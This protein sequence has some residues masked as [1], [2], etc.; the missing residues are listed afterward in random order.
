MF[1]RFFLLGVIFSFLTCAEG[2]GK[3]PKTLTTTAEGVITQTQSGTDIIETIA[4]IDDVSSSLE[5]ISVT[6]NMQS[7]FITG[8]APLPLFAP[9]SVTSVYKPDVSCPQGST[10]S[11]CTVTIPYASGTYSVG[12]TSYPI[13]A[14]LCYSEN[15]TTYKA[16]LI[17]SDSVTNVPNYI[18][19][20]NL[21]QLVSVDPSYLPVVKEFV[22]HLS[23]QTQI[24]SQSVYFFYVDISAEKRENYPD[25]KIFCGQVTP[26][27]SEWIT[28]LLNLDYF[29]SITGGI[30]L[31][32]KTQYADVDANFVCEKSKINEISLT[33]NN[34]PVDCV[35][36]FAQGVFSSYITSIPGISGEID[37]GPVIVTEEYREDGT[38]KRTICPQKF[39]CMESYGTY[40]TGGFYPSLCSTVAFS[41]MNPSCSEQDL[42]S[43]GKTDY[44]LSLF[45]SSI[46]FYSDGTAYGKLCPPSITDTQILPFQYSQNFS[47]NLTGCF[48]FSGVNCSS[49][50]CPTFDE[51]YNLLKIVST[52]DI[53]TISTIVS[54]K[55]LCDWSLTAMPEGCITAT[56]G[57]ELCV[58]TDA[59][60]VFVSGKL[61]NLNSCQQFSLSIDKDGKGTAQY[62]ADSSCQASTIVCENTTDD[63]SGKPPVTAPDPT[64][65]FY[66]NLGIVKKKC[67]IQKISAEEQCSEKECS[68]KREIST[69]KGK[70][71]EQWKCSEGSCNYKKSITT[72]DGKTVENISCSGNKDKFICSGTAKGLD[73]CFTKD[74][75]NYTFVVKIKEAYLVRE[76]E[77]NYEETDNNK[78]KKELILKEQKIRSEKLC[79][80][81]SQ[82]NLG[83]TSSPACS[84]TCNEIKRSDI[85]ISLKTE[86]DSPS[87]AVYAGE[88]SSQSKQGKITVIKDK[89]NGGLKIKG[90]ITNT[91]KSLTIQFDAT[92]E[93]TG[94]KN[95]TFKV[96]KG[97]TTVATGNIN[98]TAQGD[99]SGEIKEGDKTYSISISSGIATFCE[100]GTN[101]CSQ[102]VLSSKIE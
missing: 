33:S 44:I 13:P 26:T 52:Q 76:V 39:P 35:A 51:F 41:Q 42:N 19:G 6:E 61:C 9:P 54:S 1:K 58:K 47:Y 89:V 8:R 65:V 3:L 36:G 45:D 95:I 91:Q 81:D 64:G 62:C 7:A 69:D 53:S 88:I 96:V 55:P 84:I 71:T 43:D 92:Y 4:V 22:K 31:K 49:F 59:S 93:P 20:I 70:S 28:E 10:Q 23:E 98:I 68:G 80:L 87:T 12:T 24:I 63:L 11:E 90:E 30:G 18:T 75:N 66:I 21:M 46:I 2:K 94:D 85:E 17:F 86:Y 82:V 100:K 15:G 37:F 102:V 97:T 74:G 56:G 14:T 27:T 48:E 38:C 72:T 5:S 79:S 57:S 101:N 29:S 67:V 77:A 73:G 50:Q 60:S 78:N 83:T 25:I 99:T 16:R 34:Y 40:I 32:G